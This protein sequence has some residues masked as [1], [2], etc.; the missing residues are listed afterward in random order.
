[1][2][3]VKIKPSDIDLKGGLM[4]SEF[5][6]CEKEVIARNIILIAKNNGDTW[7]PFTWEEYCAKCTHTPSLEECRI[8][9]GFV[10]D[11]FLAMKEGRYSV[12]PTFIQKL[13]KFIKVTI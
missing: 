1:M 13:G 8:L 9:N 2:S 3:N 6:K 10:S 12:L 7:F 5:C 11:G 4:G